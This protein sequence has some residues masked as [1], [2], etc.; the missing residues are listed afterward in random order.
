MALRKMLLP[1]LAFLAG[2]ALLTG[3]ARALPADLPAT[4]T[5]H[6]TSTIPVPVDPTGAAPS[7][8]YTLIEPTRIL[9][10]PDVNATLTPLV[11]QSTSLVSAARAFKAISPGFD[12]VVAT[13]AP[14]GQATA[15]LYSYSNSAYGQIRPDGTV[16]LAYTDTHVW[17]FLIPLST[18][19]DLSQG[20]VGSG[21]VG[22]RTSQVIRSHCAYYYL[23]DAETGAFL[24]SSQECQTREPAP[25]DS[26]PAK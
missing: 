8:G 4:P 21:A 2:A 14:S 22:S 11:D 18:Y 1:S 5:A 3:C 16:K 12:N 6:A 15:G 26:L 19:L 17:A 10:W 25:V 13:G 20:A 7:D 24:T 9:S 23:V